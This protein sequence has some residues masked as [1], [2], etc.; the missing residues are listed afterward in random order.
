VFGAL[1]LVAAAMPNYV[2][3]TLVLAPIGVMSL[4]FNTSANSSVQLLSSPQMRGRVMAVYL[5]ANG[6][7]SAFGAP[8][9]GWIAQVFGPRGPF[10]FAGIAMLLAAAA[11]TLALARPTP[12]RRAPL[13]PSNDELDDER[14]REPVD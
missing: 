11:A 8:L 6:G 9:Q 5:I 1:D 4:A 7:G 13:A 10:V 14:F 12:A 3:F 2:T